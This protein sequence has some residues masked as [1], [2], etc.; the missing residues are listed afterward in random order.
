MEYE[1]CPVF[2]VTVVEQWTGSN[3]NTADDGEPFGTATRNNAM[4]T[5]KL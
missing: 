3:L 5:E 4:E 2:S 1:L